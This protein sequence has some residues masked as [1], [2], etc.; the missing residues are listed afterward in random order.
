MIFSGKPVSKTA[1]GTE[2]VQSLPVEELLQRIM[3]SKNRLLQIHS[4]RA[5][6]AKESLYAV[7]DLLR[8]LYTG[9]HED[10]K[11]EIVNGLKNPRKSGNENI[12][13]EIYGLEKSA[14]V[15]N[16]IRARVKV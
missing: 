15:R 9:I 10:V 13:R 12:L 14:S 16:A 5:L 8:L 6:L 4:V 3:Y 7:H 1:S 2:P 11:V